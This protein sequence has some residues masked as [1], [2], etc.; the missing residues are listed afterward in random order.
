MCHTHPRPDF[1]H[2]QTSPDYR[3]KY[4]KPIKGCKTTP[5]NG[6]PPRPPQASQGR[7]AVVHAASARAREARWRRAENIRVPLTCEHRARLRVMNTR[8]SNCSASCSSGEA[9]AELTAAPRRTLCVP[10]RVSGNPAAR[11]GFE[12][13]KGFLRSQR[14]PARTTTQSPRRYYPEFSFPGR[15]ASRTTVASATHRCSIETFQRGVSRA[16]HGVWSP[17]ATV[18][19]AASTNI[20]C[21]RSPRPRLLPD[22]SFRVP[23]TRRM[24]IPGPSI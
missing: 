23:R 4:N 22:I 16:Q 20:L 2:K 5:L 7:T 19:I 24:R 18:T 6:S 3:S 17:A 11:H 21:F 10:I 14:L 13:V 1:S 9:G 12:V 8:R 15:T